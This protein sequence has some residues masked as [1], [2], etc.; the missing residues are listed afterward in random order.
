MQ[1]NRSNRRPWQIAELLQIDTQEVI[2]ACYEIGVNI[3]END[4]LEPEIRDDICSTL[5][6]RKKNNESLNTAEKKTHGHEK[7]S[8]AFP[9]R[10]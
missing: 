6:K 5:K 9:R 3:K 2:K 10:T 4:L 7:K 8:S 1:K